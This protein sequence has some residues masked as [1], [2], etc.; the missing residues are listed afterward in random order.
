MDQPLWES[1]LE[2]NAWATRRLI[3]RCALL[4][5]AEFRKPFPI[6]P[7]SLHATLA[8]IIECMFY[9]ADRFREREYARRPRF[10]RSAST[11]RGQITL[12]A[13]ADA[14]LRS[15]IAGFLAARSLDDPLAGWTYEGRAI[16]ARTALMQ[17]F[18]HGSHHRAQCLNMLRRLKHLDALEVDP[19]T[20]IADR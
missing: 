19:L 4:T 20:F 6:G 5:R 9:F 10:G 11:A 15:A 13:E 1:Q 17:A 2:H 12:L 7:G 8:H 18:D 14:E 16:T 3:E